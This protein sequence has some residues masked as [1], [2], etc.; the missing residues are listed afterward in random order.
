M[1]TTSTEQF[2]VY[3]LG[4]HQNP[5]PIQSVPHGIDVINPF[6]L[7]LAPSN[8]STAPDYNHITSFY[9]AQNI[10]D[11]KLSGYGLLNLRASYLIGDKYNIALYATNVTNKKYYAS[12]IISANLAPAT[13][14]EPR[15]YGAEFTYS[16]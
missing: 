14:G 4:Y 15:I 7:N 11:P 6:R 12:G 1:T 13:V 16:F 5:S 10:S 8:K 2:V 3:R 9:M